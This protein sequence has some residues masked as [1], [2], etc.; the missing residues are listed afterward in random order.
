MNDELVCTTAQLMKI[1]GVQRHTL[2]RFFQ[3][4]MPKYRHGKFYLPDVIPWFMERLKRG[5]GRSELDSARGDLYR[6]QTEHHELQMAQK[7]REL[8]PFDECQGALNEVTQLIIATM[9]ALGPRLGGLLAGVDNPAEIEHIIEGEIR[10]CREQAAQRIREYRTRVERGGD[11]S[12]P[13]PEPQRRR[14]GRPKSNSPSRQ[15]RAGA[16]A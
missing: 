4:G 2:T 5:S 12:E 8:V 14:V 7:R 16:V 9:D 6:A 1:M 10:A 11:D 3:E 15:P 13:T